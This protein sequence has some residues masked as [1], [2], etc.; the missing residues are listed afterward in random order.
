M[1]LD[2]AFVNTASW[3]P[4]PKGSRARK[5]LLVQATLPTYSWTAANSNFR[6][7]R[8]PPGRVVSGQNGRGLFLSAAISDKLFGAW[9]LDFILLHIFDNTASYATTFE[10]GLIP[11]RRELASNIN[12]V[13]GDVVL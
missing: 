7:C 12:H 6:E 3:N 11:C 4:V 8:H 9:E 1:I 13:G 10:G 5:S 2:Y